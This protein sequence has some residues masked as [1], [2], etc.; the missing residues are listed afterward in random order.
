[1]RPERQGQLLLLFG[2]H[3]LQ[4]APLTAGDLELFQAYSEALRS[5]NLLDYDNLIARTGELLRARGDALADVSG[6][7]DCVLVD[8]FQDLSLAQYEVVTHL[9]T[10]HRNCFAVG[11]DEQSIF[12]WTGAD[13]RILDRFRTDFGIAAPIV[14]ELNRRCSR[15]I[16]ET[17]RRLVTQNPGLFEKRLEANRESE[18]GVASH[19]FD[20]EAAEAEW[21]VA[22]LAGDRAA[23]GLDWGDYGIL[24]RAHRIGQR[25]E[26]ALIEAGV[27]CL[28]AR[29]QA[30]LDDELIGFIVASLRIIRTPDDP[31]P[32][33]A[34]AE[35]V[36]PRPL[37][38]RIRAS[39]R[40]L[41]PLT[42]LRA[43]TRVARRDPD[44]RQVWRFI[45]HVENLAG[46]GRTHESLGA[47]VDALLAQRLG[48]YRNPL[49]EHAPELT[50]PADL[51][52]AAHLAD[53][54][55]GT[56]DRAATV[57]LEPDRGVDLALLP[58]LRAVVGDRV[59][60]LE[61]G[62]RPRAGD[63]LLRAGSVRP[64]L[65]F[66]A[67]QLLQCRGL[68]DPLQDY[69]A[70]DLETTEM[71]VAACEVVELAAV[72]VRGRVVV[73]QFKQLIRTS[74]PISPQATAV[75]GLGDADVCDQPA[76]AEVWPAVR[77]FVGS[78]L[79]VA[80]N[81]HT[82]DVPVL[83]RLA[84]GLPGL[85]ELVFLDTLPLARSLVEGSAK[86]EDL[87]HRFGV[88]TGRSHRALDDAA[89]LAG[90]VRHLGEL[91]LARSRKVA[92]VQLLGWLG[93]ALALDAPADPSPE[94]RLLREVALPAALGRYGG[95]LETYAE[96]A[97]GTAAPPV[98]ELI[99]R[100]GG[101]RLLE[102]IRTQRS[103]AERYPASAARLA[104]LVE[105][106]TA[107]TLAESIDRL[108][109]RV[110][111]SRSDGCRTDDR[112]VSL[113]TLHAT[114]GLEFSRVYVVGAEDNQLPGW[115]ALEND[116]QP[117]LQ[118]ARRLLYVGMT[119]AKDRLVLTRAVL[120]DGRST[121]GA[122]FL[123]EAGLEQGVLD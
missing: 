25:L 42:A 117:E 39:H 79:L 65:V 22:D 100:L 80:H 48:R 94:E 109:E 3:R 18:H 12:S 120:R 113:L 53:R 63:L 27:P 89:A 46:L 83:R 123:R 101:Q 35:Q 110:A 21:L 82:F 92:L 36:L 37:L 44:T 107:P 71:D 20:D 122:L 41:D 78:D 90:V 7:W 118:E 43:F 23:S 119:R 16:F 19:V 17:A 105:A 76:F 6:R 102:R 54:L 70:F 58:M 61:P 40:G 49:D 45:F 108:L 1:M 66:K 103:V 8:E 2:R 74:R 15:Q 60:R 51:P 84:A 115:H 85:E 38:D 86:L 81:G 114:K 97:A 104:S 14:L 111:L 32:I 28:M 112:R 96:E 121:G 4:H 69:V 10:R 34:F 99:E 52:G 62:D 57:W 47:L 31:L 77:E 67:L 64:L 11:D 116:D 68:A 56:R 26:T 91:R 33:D 59:Q 98:E 87:A 95:C 24:Y 50:D 72:R 106:S 55:A 73:A 30:L 93:L 5:R 88:P 13:P 29:G 9:A 75:H